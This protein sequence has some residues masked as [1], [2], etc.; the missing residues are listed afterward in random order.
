MDVHL[1]GQSLKLSGHWIRTQAE[2]LFLKVNPDGSFEA[3]VVVQAQ[4]SGQMMAAAS[5]IANGL[6]GR[7]V[8]GSLMN[9]PEVIENYSFGTS[10]VSFM[11]PWGDGEA[12]RVQDAGPWL[13]QSLEALEKF[14]AR[15]Q[16][17]WTALQAHA[18]FFLQKNR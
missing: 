16:S 12:E 13:Q 8:V 2:G 6:T 15:H 17:Q 3:H 7:L 11:T 9:N 5:L 1:L 14:Y 4:P 10:T 18:D